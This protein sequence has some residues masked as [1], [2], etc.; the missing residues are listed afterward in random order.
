[1][2]RIEAT[3]RTEKLPQVVRALNIVWGKGV[4]ITKLLGRRVR[5]QSSRSRRRAVK[6]ELAPRMR[7]ELVVEDSQVEQIVGALLASARTG[8]E[9][10]GKIF[11]SPVESVI[12]IR[13]GAR[14]RLAM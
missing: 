8:E 4:M 12:R 11:I 14:G 7:I 1:M 13:N 10:D 2:K 9:G 5:G 3:V 6:A